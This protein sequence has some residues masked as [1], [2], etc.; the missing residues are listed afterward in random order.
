MFDRLVKRNQQSILVQVYSHKL[1]LLLVA[2]SLLL[3]PFSRDSLHAASTQAAVYATVETTP[4]LHT[5]DAADDMAV[6]IHPTDTSL[7][8]IIGADRAGNLEVYDLHGN[9]LQRIPFKNNNVDLRYNFPLGGKKVA[10][11][12]GVDRTTHRLF[13]YKVNPATRLLEDVSANNLSIGGILGSAMYVSPKTLKYYVFTNLDSVMHQYELYDDGT[14]KVAAR[15]VRTVTFGSFVNKTEG[16]VA[17]D[18]HGKVYVS[19]EWV[20]IWELGAEPGDGDAK[21]MVD[22]PIADGGHFQPDVEGLAIYYKSDGKGYLIASSQGNR[23]YVVYT[24]EGNHPYLGT[25]EIAEGVIDGT[26]GTDGIDVTN[27]PLG[28]IFPYGVFLAQDGVNTDTS[29]AKNQN[30]KLVPFQSIA[31]ALN[32][33][34]DT[35]WDPRKVGSGDNPPPPPPPSPTPPPPTNSDYSYMPIINFR[36]SGD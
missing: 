22:R 20:A 2:F 34:M 13:A 10:L 32:L 21:V 7:S 18:V 23:T 8:T 6:W 31:N 11:V 35:T 17:D 1:P 3:I 33:T 26:N 28:N 14:G 19:E 24:R 9:V 27:F 30:F 29:S 16:V 12:T 15:L 5:G 4:V 25:F 36:G